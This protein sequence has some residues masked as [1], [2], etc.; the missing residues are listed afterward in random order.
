MRPSSPQ[1]D[2]GHEQMHL[3]GATKESISEEMER[4]CYGDCADYAAALQERDPSLKFG[5]H[6]IGDNPYHAFAH[7]NEKAYDYLG[8]HDLP[9]DIDHQDGRT[10]LN[11]S[12]DDLNGI[13]GILPDSV[14]EAHEAINR[15]QGATQYDL[16]GNEAGQVRSLHGRAPQVNRPDFSARR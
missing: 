5:V 11:L 14:E 7:D 16:Q 13:L 10:T 1:T 4:W 15:R 8:E 9:Y 12:R 3:M 2:Y 6:H